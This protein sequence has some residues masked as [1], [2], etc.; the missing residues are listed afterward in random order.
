MNILFCGT[1]EFAL[2]ILKQ[3]LDS[4][5]NLQGVVTQPDRPRG[6]GRK[7]SSPPVKEYMSGSEIPVYQPGSSQELIEIIDR[8]QLRPDVIV[9]VSYGLLLPVPVLELPPLG[10][11]NLHPSLLPAYR[12]AAPIQRAIMNGDRLTGITTMYLSKEM[13]AGDLILQEKA[14]IPEDATAGDMAGVLAEQGAVLMLKTLAMLQAGTV[15]RR[16]QD[17]EQA[18]YAPPLNKD[19]GKIGWDQ[20]ANGICNQIRGM[21]PKPGAYTVL[22]GRVLKIW[23]SRVCNEEIPGCSPGEIVNIDPKVGFSVETGQGQLFLTEVQPAG[24][25]RMTAAEFVRGY[26]ISPGMRLG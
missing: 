13:D 7:M 22:Q 18:S 20:D 6:R 17:N 4:K 15:S 1:S 14:E 26:R 19:E 3:V 24:R 16:I 23:G 10:C 12:G 25:Q 21:N 11:V 2:P 9:V 8:A 5:W